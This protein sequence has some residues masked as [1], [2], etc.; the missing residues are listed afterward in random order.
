MIGPD[1]PAVKP[2]CVEGAKVLGR[3][4]A[5]TGS[6]N[7]PAVATACINT[8]LPHLTADDLRSTPAG[9]ALMAEAWEEGLLSGEVV[10]RDWDGKL[11]T[12]LAALNPYRKANA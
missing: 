10:L 4:V 11:V 12:D 9:Q 7:M 5:R 8:A 3:T 1:H 6:I 2:A